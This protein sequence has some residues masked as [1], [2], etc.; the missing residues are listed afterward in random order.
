MN[1]LP[2]TERAGAQ[3]PGKSTPTVLGCLS[4]VGVTVSLFG[5][6][7][8]DLACIDHARN[9]RPIKL[10][11]GD[12]R[13][14]RKR[15]AKELMWQRLNEPVES[16]RRK[17]KRRTWSAPTCKGSLGSLKRFFA[18]LDEAGIRFLHE[19][20]QEYADAFAMKVKD[21]VE[22]RPHVA[23][24][25]KI[26]DCLYEARDHLT[27]GGLHFVPFGARSTMKVADVRKPKENLTS[28]IPEPVI[29]ILLAWALAYVDR[30]SADILAAERDY[31][32]VGH[33][34]T[35]LILQDAARAFSTYVEEEAAR[36]GGVPA[37]RHKG[38][39]QA[40]KTLIA[41]R[42]G[43]SLSWLR[44]SGAPALS[45]AIARHGF[46]E[47]CLVFG[48]STADQ[49]ERP[50][51]GAMSV[52]EMKGECVHLSIACYVVCAYLSGM[53]DSEVQALERDCL[54][55]IFDE[56]G[57]PLRYRLHGL[58]FKNQAVPKKASWVVIGPVARAVAV[59]LELTVDHFERTADP[60]LFVRLHWRNNKEGGSALFKSTVCGLLRDFARHCSEDLA[61][62]LPAG[63][64]SGPYRLAPIP[65]APG[66]P[67]HFVTSQFRRTMAWHIANRPFGVVAGMIQYK[68]AS[69]QMFEG[70][71]G[72]SK[73]DFRAEVE[74]EELHAR[75]GDIV[76]MW[77][78]AQAGRLPAGPM[79]PE[80]VAVFEA[81]SE[82]IGPSP[83]Q[84]ADSKR[85]DA[86]VRQKARQL[87]PGLLADCFYVP[88]QARCQKATPVEL[89]IE[90]VSGL[91]DPDCPRACWSAKHIGNW[92]D[93]E[94]ETLRLRNL[95]RGPP[96]QRDILEDRLADIRRYIAAIEEA[97]HGESGY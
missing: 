4:K 74:A 89:R 39:L 65:E 86:L 88:S 94:A 44:T 18:F 37:I 93:L 13:G 24:I 35:S 19:V 72:D 11:F 60:H 47:R 40:A 95:N 45:A 70:Y 2:Q 82:A 77:T 67:W 28:R 76:E 73:S 90:P 15:I 41:S 27:G 10:R 43:V 51:R 61:P 97:S 22:S 59:L 57:R 9:R 53:R 52:A 54:Q 8:W 16:L 55:T 36:M 17:G 23:S 66:G 80:L 29:G 5:D 12:L 42:A 32:G 46:A 1:V 81:I 34:E 3:R 96:I 49:A 38:R 63:A 56:D 62:G 79:A 64:A 75:Q 78:D 87:Y 20:T 91:C 69:I 48:V 50:W 14:D 7:V 21:E 26:M 33:P 83:C 25:L 30:F 58:T 6:D 92:R 68:H 84:V 85:A 71:A 31:R